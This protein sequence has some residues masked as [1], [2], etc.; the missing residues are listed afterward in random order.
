MKKKKQFLK[1]KNSEKIFS[2]NKFPKINFRKK[3]Q[4]NNCPKKNFQ[5]KKMQKKIQKK[6]KIFVSK[7]SARKSC[8]NFGPK[9]PTVC[10]RRLQLSAGARKIAARRAAIF[11]VIINALI[12]TLGGA[13]P[14]F[15]RALITKQIQRLAVIKTHT[16][17]AASTPTAQA[18]KVPEVEVEVGVE[19]A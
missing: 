8:T 2:K 13:S 12:P 7:T 18:R 5:T 10:R 9:G 6:F 14:V 4:K 1:K 19:I 17:G 15:C 3:F 16:L 11:L